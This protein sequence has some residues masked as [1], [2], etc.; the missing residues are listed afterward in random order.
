M[1]YLPV[2]LG[3]LLWLLYR[4]CV[5]VT[6]ALTL[7]RLWNIVTLY[8]INILAIKAGWWEFGPSEI[9]LGSVPLLPLFGW[10][11]IWEICFPLIPTQ[12]G[13]ALVLLAVVADLLFMPLLDSFGHTQIHMARWRTCRHH[14]CIYSRTID[15]S[16]DG[17]ETN[18]LGTSCWTICNFWFP[19][20]LFI[21]GPDIRIGRRKAANH[22]DEIL[23]SSYF[24]NSTYA[25]ICRIG[26]ACCH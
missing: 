23:D 22:S 6:G 18:N 2:V 9:Q 16:L 4:P 17:H 11:I 14:V 20:H 12:H 15:V 1:L 21:A 5:K 3:G 24:S 25:W 26:R 13:T 19:D 7:S 10:A 8:L